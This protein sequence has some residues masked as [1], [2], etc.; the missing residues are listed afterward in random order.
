MRTATWVLA[1]MSMA[2][3]CAAP[4]GVVGVLREDGSLERTAD[5]PVRPAEKD[6]ALDLPAPP[7]EGWEQ[8]AVGGGRAR[9]TGRF[10]PGAEIPAHWSAS[11][12]GTEITSRNK[13]YRTTTDFGIFAVHGY[14]EVIT[15]SVG[16]EEFRR[17]R[18][19][20]IEL[21]LPLAD[22]WLDRM[23][24]AEYEL[25]AVKAFVRRNVVPTMERMSDKAYQYGL[26]QPAAAPNPR[27]L[28]RRTMQPL[29]EAGVPADEDNP[30]SRAGKEM[31]RLWAAAKA[32]ELVRRKG[33]AELTFAEARALVSLGDDPEWR[34]R[35]K[36]VGDALVAE[37]YGSREAFEAVARRL[38]GRMT[39]VYGGPLA[40]FP[41]F[42]FRFDLEMPGEIVSGNGTATGPASMRWRFFE[43]AL[44]PAG[45][46]MTAES[47]T[48]RPAA[49]S[50]VFGGRMPLPD[51]G[52]VQRFRNEAL[53]G[54][55]PAQAAA[56]AAALRECVSGAGLAPLRRL[57]ETTGGPAAR[58][59]AALGG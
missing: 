9:M 38:V 59:L 25:A 11:L 18:A 47:V 48:V 40:V 5:Q 33:G 39:G 6:F 22:E 27:E 53:T 49:Q 29:K 23:F 57:A 51:A 58:A 1:A 19:E 41:R 56:V 10:S 32:K 13:V 44:F 54:A 46:E 35:A 17:A 16:A 34:R 36:E 14:R 21:C 37:K 20:L 2:A 45:L 55:T 43:H 42:A 4:V 15:N 7:A 12:R 24:G 3:G 31:A 50:A 30:F 52:S 28:I 26:E 8:H